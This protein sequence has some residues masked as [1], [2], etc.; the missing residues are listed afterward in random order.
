MFCTKCGNQFADGSAFCPSCGT[1]VQAAPQQPVYQQPVQP[2]YQQPVYQQPVQPQYQQPAPQA[3]PAGAMDLKKIWHMI[4]A[5]VAA[6]ALII[7][8]LTMFSVF[9]MPLSASYEGESRTEYGPVSE[10]ADS[11]E[12]MDKSFALGYVAN[13]IMGLAGIAAGAVGILYF[14]KQQKNMPYYDQFVAKYLKGMT[15]G[16]AVG[17]LAAAGVVLQFI[18]LL[19]TGF[20]TYGIEVSVSIPWISWIVLVLGAGLAVVD[21]V[22]IN[23]K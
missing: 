11:Y 1:P 6:F 18:L 13:I 12:V 3:A 22:M 21:K 20:E 5:G 19:L 10:I 2:Q 4:I 8:L 16:F 9:E 23:K 15:P 17:V 14:L 7:G